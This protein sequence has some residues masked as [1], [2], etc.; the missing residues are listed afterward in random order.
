MSGANLAHEVVN[1][2]AGVTQI[3]CEHP[4]TFDRLRPLIETPR[5]RVVY[6]RDIIGTTISAT[7]KKRLCDWVRDTQGF[8]SGAG[9]FPRHVHHTCD[10]R[11]QAIRTSHGCGAETFDAESQVWIADLLATCHGGR[12]ALF[13]R[14]LAAMD[15]KHGKSVPAS[16]LLEQFHKRKMAVEGF[17]ACRLAQRIA[18]QRGFHPPILGEIYSILHGGKKVDVDAFIEKCLDTLSHK[19]TYPTP[20]AIPYRSRNR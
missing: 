2:G 15:D 1:G 13:G 11:D 4:E 10:G 19:S 9:E 18:A 5:F 17:E 16:F 14:E 8:S 3:A 20:S 12:S 7:L 6:S